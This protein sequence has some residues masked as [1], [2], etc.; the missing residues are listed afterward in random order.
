MQANTFNCACARGPCLDTI[1]VYSSMFIS[2]I[3]LNIFTRILHTIHHFLSLYVDVLG[4]FFLSPFCPCNQSVDW[5]ETLQS[6][7]RTYSRSNIFLASH[8]AG[9]Q[10]R[11]IYTY[12]HTH[13]HILIMHMCVCVVK[14]EII[15]FHTC[16]RNI[17]HGK[18]N[19][20]LFFKVALSRYLFSWEK[21]YFVSLKELHQVPWET[22]LS[23]IYIL[24][25][26]I[27]KVKRNKNPILFSVLEIT[28]FKIKTHSKTCPP[29][30]PIYR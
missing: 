3:L 2:F 26:Y 17:V 14:L 29:P 16:T 11:H 30:L 27:L 8:P 25:D 22:F 1:D 20:A 24:E 19:M 21:T 4:T 7:L 12:A 10:I 6:E 28:L 18:Q 9:S 23:E 15:R 5:G 13:T